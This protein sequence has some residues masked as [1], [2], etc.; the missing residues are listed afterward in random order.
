MAVELE[1]GKA[2]ALA[3][4]MTEHYVAMALVP[5]VVALFLLSHELASYYPRIQAG[6]FSVGGRVVL[7]LLF[8]IVLPAVIVSI[9]VRRAI[10]CYRIFRRARAEAALTWRLDGTAITAEGDTDK[11]RPELAFAVTP[12]LGRSVAAASAPAR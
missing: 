12:K 4:H 5:F 6:T 8:A 11:A 10:R 7:E 9:P 3:K 1:P 2:E